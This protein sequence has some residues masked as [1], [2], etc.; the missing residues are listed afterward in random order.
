L[1]EGVS[2]LRPLTLQDVATE[3]EVHESTVSR[4]TSGKYMI[5]PRGIF[6]LK[7]FFTAGTAAINGGDSQSVEVVRHRIKQL[8]DDETLS[9]VL[10]DEDLVG[11]LHSEGMKVARRTVAKYRESMRIPSSAQRRRLLRLEAG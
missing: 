4:V 6:E 8:V 9:K 3:V 11:L 2:G 1:D 10:S 5:T 7:Y